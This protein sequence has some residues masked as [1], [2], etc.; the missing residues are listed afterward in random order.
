MGRNK[1][2]WDRE[3]PPAEF[4]H[5]DSKLLIHAP[6]CCPH[7]GGIWR[8]VDEGYCCTVCGRRW[9]AGDKLRELVG[10]T[11][12]HAERWPERVP[13]PSRKRAS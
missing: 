6:P 10:R 8:G 3:L 4:P 9:R 5:V 1:G 11:T 2:A 12:D 7:C 13:V